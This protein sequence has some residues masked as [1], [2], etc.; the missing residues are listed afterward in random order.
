MKKYLAMCAALTAIPFLNGCALF[1]SSSGVM[2]ANNGQYYFISDFS[3]CKTYKYDHTG[4]SNLILCYDENEHYTGDV[5]AMTLQDFNQYMAYQAAQR[6]QTNAMLQS[7]SN[8]LNESLASL[9]MTSQRNYNL[10]MNTIAAQRQ[11]NI[12]QLQTFNNR[13]SFRK[14]FNLG[15]YQGY[16]GAKYQYDLS[17]PMQRSD[18]RMDSDAQI[19]D[20]LNIDVGTL[21]DRTMGQYGGGYF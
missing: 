15:S 10:L 8:Q 14:S 18:Y 3:K 4:Q 1:E 2:K 19:R 17:D 11:Q 5:R 21:L 7:L 16:S 12:Y 13:P 9:N 20:S 6:A